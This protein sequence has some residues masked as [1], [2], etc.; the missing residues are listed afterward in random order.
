[1]TN[2]HSL[3]PSSTMDGEGTVAQSSNAKDVLP[4][5]SCGKCNGTCK[6]RA[7]HPK[8]TTGGRG[9]A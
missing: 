5:H 8:P 9:A 4:G 3:T 1:M 6:E 7:L 2:D